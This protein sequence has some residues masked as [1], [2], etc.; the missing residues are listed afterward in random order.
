MDLGIEPYVIASALIGVVAQRLVRRMCTNCR[1]QYTPT[2]E[3][4]R[5][6]NL[7]EAE[8]SSALFYH[9]VGCEQ[10]NYTGYH[11]RIGVYEVMPVSTR[12][13]RLIA[14]RNPEDGLREMACQEGM[15]TLGEDGLSKV[16]SGVTTAD[17][18]LRAVTDAREVRTVCPG[19]HGAIGVDFVACPH[20][21]RTLISACP[22][23]HRALQ[24]TWTFCPYCSTDTEAWRKLRHIAQK[25][26]RELAAANVAE[27]KKA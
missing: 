23:C 5:L 7:N 19:C 1:R 14:D 18:L 25:D 15:V 3:T 12:L 20:C 10:C 9:P 24:P 16:R 22:R 17:E 6:L 8:A 11:G 26:Q 4:V 13:R 21:G 2:P 27:F